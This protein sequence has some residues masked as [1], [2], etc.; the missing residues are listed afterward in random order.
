MLGKL[1][2][3][4]LERAFVNASEK[5]FDDGPGNDAEPA[6]LRERGRVELDRFGRHESSVVA[7]AA[8]TPS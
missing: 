8:L 2:A 6:E 3:E 1:D 5:P 4:A 7:G